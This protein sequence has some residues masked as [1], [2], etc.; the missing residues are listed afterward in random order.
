MQECL[1]M[2]DPVPV[3]LDKTTLKQIEEGDVHFVIVGT[4]SPFSYTD[5][6]TDSRREINLPCESP[7]WQSTGNN[8]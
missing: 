6:P 4:S 3:D 2:Q 7:T 5:G 8:E 1:S